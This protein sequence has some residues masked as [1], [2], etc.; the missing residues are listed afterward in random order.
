MSKELFTVFVI[1]FP[2]SG[3]IGGLFHYAM[4]LHYIFTRYPDIPFPKWFKIT[5][6]V[7][8]CIT[9]ILGLIIIIFYKPN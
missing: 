6:A 9:L 3:I 2:A 7:N 5:F 8:V 4:A 1:L